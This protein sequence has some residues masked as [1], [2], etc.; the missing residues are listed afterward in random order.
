MMGQPGASSP[1]LESAFK[2]RVNSE[3]RQ[4]TDGKDVME[5]GSPAMPKG[6]SSL[7]LIF[8]LYQPKN[9]FLFSHYYYYYYYFA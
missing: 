5:A 4:M 3:E 7:F 2:D 6:S 9:S 8:Q 1:C